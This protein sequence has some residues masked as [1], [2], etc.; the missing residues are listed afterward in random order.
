AAHLLLGRRARRGEARPEPG[1]VGVFLRRSRERRKSDRL[2]PRRAPDVPGAERADR[3]LLP[4][5][6][7][8]AARRPRRVGRRHAV[9]SVTGF[10]ARRRSTTAARF[11]PTTTALPPA[12]IARHGVPGSATLPASNPTSA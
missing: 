9:G 10:V 2:Q 3:A 5:R 12:R 8:E 1:G 7:K 6:R 4:A 11:S